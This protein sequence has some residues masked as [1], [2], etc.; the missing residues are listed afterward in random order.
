[1]DR[2]GS[3]RTVEK[4]TGEALNTRAVLFVFTPVHTWI[5]TAESHEC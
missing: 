2:G 3:V 5:I 4:G 1:M